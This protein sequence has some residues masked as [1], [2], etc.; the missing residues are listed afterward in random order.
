MEQREQPQL[1][2]EDQAALSKQPVVLLKMFNSK[3]D[4]KDWQEHFESVAGVNRWPEQDI[5]LWLRVRFVDNGAK[6][7]YSDCVTAL[8]EQFDSGTKRELYLAE[9][10]K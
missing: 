7:S 8:K 9:A 3:E 2:S 4:W 10:T 6:G 1:V 5:L